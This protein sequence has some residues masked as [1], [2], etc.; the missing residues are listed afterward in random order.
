MAFDPMKLTPVNCPFSG[1]AK[2]Y[3]YSTADDITAGGYFNKVHYKLSVGDVI[4][5]CNPGDG[6]VALHKVTASAPAGVT[7]EA[8]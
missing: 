7:V 3:T 5:K 6:S 1:N 2:M 4:I 8:N